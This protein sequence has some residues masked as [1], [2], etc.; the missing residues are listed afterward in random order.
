MT[1]LGFKNLTVD[2]W[3][4]PDKVSSSF[5][6]ISPVDGQAHPIAGNEW[7]CDILKPTLVESV[8]TEIRALFEV[9]RGALV[10][11]YFFYP[12]YTLAGEQLF[13][14]AEAAVTLKC[15]AMGAPRSSTRTFEDKLKYLTSNKVV[16]EKERETWHAIRQLRNIASHPERQSIF[17]PGPV[18]GILERTAERI[19]SLFSGT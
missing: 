8:P 7:V 19:N 5:V 14:V 1:N 6:R 3:L 4:E 15:K 16:P 11:G 10:Y 17:P 2:N 13:R 9:A 18:I 12:L